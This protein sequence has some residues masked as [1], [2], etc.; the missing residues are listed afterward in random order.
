M[1]DLMLMR[2]IAPVVRIHAAWKC[3]VKKWILP[4][5]EE[6]CT[7][8]E[9]FSQEEAKYLGVE[10]LRTLAEIREVYGQGRP[11]VTPHRLV[12]YRAS[13]IVPGR[14]TGNLRYALLSKTD[15]GPDSPFN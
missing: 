6:M 7:R 4:A 13:V 12:G 9:F 8:E 15:A 3:D 14:G 5:Y 1:D 11:V 10:R 2:E